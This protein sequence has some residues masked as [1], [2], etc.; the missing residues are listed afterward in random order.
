MRQLGGSIGLAIFTVVLNNKFDV[1]LSSLLSSEQLYDLKRSLSTLGRLSLQQ[2]AVV[3]SIFADS[4]NEQM[5]I[6]MYL[7][8]GALLAAV[9]TYSRQPAS[10]AE[11]QD[12]QKAMMQGKTDL[13]MIQTSAVKDS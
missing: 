4:F 1:Q 10:I 3:G 2:Q 13:D 5:R 6:C 8:I 9:A 7:A 11:A 12:R